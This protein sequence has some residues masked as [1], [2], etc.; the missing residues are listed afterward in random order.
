MTEL[1]KID[2]LRELTKAAESVFKEIIAHSCQ[3]SDFYEEAS[4]LKQRDSFI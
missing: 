3:T 4:I 2:L 1:P